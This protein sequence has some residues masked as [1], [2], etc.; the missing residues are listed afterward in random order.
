MIIHWQDPDPGH[1][2]AAVLVLRYCG[3]A[4]LRYCG[5]GTAALWYLDCDTTDSGTKVLVRQYWYCYLHDRDYAGTMVVVSCHL[6]SA[7]PGGPVPSNGATRMRM[8]ALAALAG[9]SFS[10]LK[11]GPPLSIQH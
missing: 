4:V 5:T 11:P 10:N 2:G 7:R 1:S 6:A 8:P 9:I 3:T